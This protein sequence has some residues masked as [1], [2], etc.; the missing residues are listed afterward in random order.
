ME[1]R[2]P[3]SNM[4]KRRK[5]ERTQSLAALTIRTPVLHVLPARRKKR[6]RKRRNRIQK[7]LLHQLQRRRYVTAMSGLRQ[8]CWV[9]QC[10]N[11]IRGFTLLKGTQCKV[12]CN[13]LR[14]IG[15]TIVFPPQ[16]RQLLLLQQRL[17]FREV[18]KKNL[19]QS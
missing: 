7:L 3:T 10:C 4:K 14:Y 12:C 17:I 5:K 1:R 19:K 9:R 8:W 2:K 18:Y 11:S 6:T 16:H 15:V 13:S